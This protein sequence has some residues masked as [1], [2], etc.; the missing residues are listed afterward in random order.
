MG[1]PPLIPVYPLK[2]PATARPDPNEYLLFLKA[3][4][5]RVGWEQATPCPCGESAETVEGR[6]DCPICG[7]TGQDYLAS[8]EVTAVV[9]AVGLRDAPYELLGHFGFGLVHVA[10]APEQAPGFGD[11]YTLLDGVA[12]LTDLVERAA[13]KDRLRW[14]IAQVGLY[15]S[16]AGVPTQV[17]AS[18]IKLRRQDADGNGGPVLE[19]GT[20]FTVDAQGRIDWT[21][22]DV[23]HTAPAVGQRYAVRYFGHPRY[24]V[25]ERPHLIRDS[26]SG[27]LAG[28]RK[29]QPAG[30]VSL[31]VMALARLDWERRS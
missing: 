21:L 8:Q 29:Q 19:L 14:P 30:P 4:G 16:V 27:R 25:L 11:R 3:Y 18:V 31:P 24:V 28:N 20:D 10:V 13:T 7:G 17:S 9:T 6:F 1:L 23:A 12:V 22:G 15:L 5:L 26:V 2:I